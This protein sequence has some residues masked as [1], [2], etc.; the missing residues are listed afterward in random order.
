MRQCGAVL[1]SESYRSCLF[2]IGEIRGGG[3][4]EVSA[5]KIMAVRFRMYRQDT[6]ENL[7]FQLQVLTIILRCSSLF[8]PLNF[9]LRS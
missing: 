5:H 9:V 2:V 1:G 3:E 8:F 6:A 7:E 4:E